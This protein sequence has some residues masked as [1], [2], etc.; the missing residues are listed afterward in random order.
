MPGF[1][2]ADNPIAGYVR[3]AIFFF[4]GG[5]IADAH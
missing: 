2:Q 5:I 4:D 3:A 1:L